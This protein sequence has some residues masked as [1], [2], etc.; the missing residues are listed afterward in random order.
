MRDYLEIGD[1]VTVQDS[2]G[3]EVRGRVLSVSRG[4]I[5]ITTHDNYRE[6]LV[7]HTN[8]TAVLS[9]RGDEVSVV[10]PSSTLND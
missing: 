9:A 4:E 10:R 2:Q 5:L 3:R 1:E 7:H 6:H 8:P